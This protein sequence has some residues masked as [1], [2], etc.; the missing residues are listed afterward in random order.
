MRV[1]PRGLP[2]VSKKEGVWQAPGPVWLSSG[3]GG[4]EQL[5]HQKLWKQEYL[6]ES[7]YQR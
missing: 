2:S 1:G 5:R 3:T 7:D 4:A 6:E